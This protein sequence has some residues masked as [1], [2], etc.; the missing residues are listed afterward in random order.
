MRDINRRELCTCSGKMAGRANKRFILLVLVPLVVLLIAGGFYLLGGRY[1]KT[2]NAYVHADMVSVVPEVSGKVSRVAVQENQVVKAGGLLFAIEPERY[3]IAVQKAEAELAD[4]QTRIETMKASYREKQQELSVAQSNLV[5]AQREY[6]RQ[7]ELADKHAVSD[8][9]LDRY[10]HETELARQQVE[11]VQKG[12]QRIRAGL[13]GDPDI[14]IGDHPLYRKA[15][16]ALNI[17]RR[18]L[19]DTHVFARF[20]GI[21]SKTPV[22]GQYVNPSRPA[23]SLVS[24][25][26]VWVDANLKE[27][28]LTHV[29]PGQAVALEVDAYPGN[30][31][32]GRVSS[33]AGAAGSEFSILPAQNATGNWV[34]VVQRIPVRIELDD[35]SAGPRLL[36]GMSVSVAIDTGWHNRGP[37]FLAPLTTWAQSLVGPAKASERPG[38]AE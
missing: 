36:S 30:I 10:R 2:E 15:Q 9:V 21:A 37:A 16:S 24:S 25:T 1:V 32:K 29:E 6:K 18:D 34:K 31:W 14:A 22:A 20:D 13:G 12:L 7:V 17:A 38:A 4:V 28:Q 3:R 19:Q 23:M 26:G 33:I 8:S 27:T 5:F 35:P 11:Q